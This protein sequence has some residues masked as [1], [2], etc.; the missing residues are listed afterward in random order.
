MRVRKAFL[1]GGFEG[2]GIDG[3]ERVVQVNAR[4]QC[5]VVDRRLTIGPV[6]TVQVQATASA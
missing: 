2:V 4:C 6:E 3:C 5:A 1:H